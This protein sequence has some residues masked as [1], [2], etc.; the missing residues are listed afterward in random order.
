MFPHF[1]GIGAQKSGTSWLHKNLQH[2]PQIWFPPIKEIHYFDRSSTK[3]RVLQLNTLRYHRQFKQA[4]RKVK[5]GQHIGW[6]W[7]Y[8]FL[9]CNDHWYAS[10]FSP[11]AGQIAGEITPRY[12]ILAPETVGKIHSLMPNTK[13]IFLLRNP[14]DRTWSQANRRARQVHFQGKHTDETVIKQF[15]EMDDETPHRRSDYLSLL[16]LW[17]TFYPTEQILIG[18]FEQIA[19]NPRQLLSDLYQFLDVDCSEQYIPD[20]IHQKVHVGHYS[21]I[22]A[23]WAR[24]LAERY[25]EQL[26]LLHDRFD[27]HSTASWLEVAEQYLSV[28]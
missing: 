4:W 14:I 13:I 5:K 23:H 1:L 21:P 26:K 8:F 16:Q 19:E 2:H 17:E 3:P 25:H 12:S 7:R 9:P 18:F 10:L 11:K 22:P 28:E 27:N 20:S 15:M 24:Y 6:Y